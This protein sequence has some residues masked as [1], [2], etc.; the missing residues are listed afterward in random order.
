M[1]MNSV[2]DGMKESRLEDIHGEIVEMASV[3]SKEV[4]FNVR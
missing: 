1:S 4:L 2:L 3:N